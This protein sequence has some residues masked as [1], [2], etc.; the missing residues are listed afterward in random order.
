M[1]DLMVTLEAIDAYLA[2][3]P[4]NLALCSE[5]GKAF[6][7]PVTTEEALRYFPSVD[8]ASFAC[9]A[10]SSMWGKDEVSE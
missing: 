3:H 10:C 7:K 9:S 2:E 5:C 6:E 4:P 1:T 8:L